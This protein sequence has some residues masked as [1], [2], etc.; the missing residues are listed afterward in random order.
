MTPLNARATKTF[1]YL[2]T[3][4]Y[5]LIYPTS[6]IFEVISLFQR[7][8]PTPTVTAKL[9]E[10]ISNDQLLI[11]IVDADILKNSVALFNPLRSKK[12]TL[13]NRSM[14]AVA[15]KLHADGILAYDSFYTKQGLKLASDLIPQT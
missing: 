4:G 11:H 3:K 7:V 6:V 14:V 8:L 9:V 10:M 2:I 12:N 5:Q 15:K 1:Q 13:I